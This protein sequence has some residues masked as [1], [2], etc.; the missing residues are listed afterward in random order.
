MNG[1]R[2]QVLK[3]FRHSRDKVFQVPSVEWIE[4]RLEQLKEILERSAERSGLILRG[5]LGRIRLE[6][7][8][9]HWPTVLSGQDVP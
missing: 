9:E 7:T 6:P 8:S 2:S 1:Y 5:L 4:E 3:G